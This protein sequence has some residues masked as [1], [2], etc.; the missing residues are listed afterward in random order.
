LYA[1]VNGNPISLTDPLGLEGCSQNIP[2]SINNALNSIASLPNQLISQSQKAWTDNK[3]ELAQIPNQMFEGI[4]QAYQGY[5]Y[6]TPWGAIMQVMN[7]VTPPG[8]WTL[9]DCWLDPGGCDPAAFGPLPQ[10]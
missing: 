6:D 5:K 9:V 8:P 2:N 1:Y 10:L 4:Q 3:N 7:A